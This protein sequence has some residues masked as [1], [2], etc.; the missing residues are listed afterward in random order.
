MALSLTL[1]LGFSVLGAATDPKAAILAA[2]RVQPKT[3][4]ALLADKVA[5]SKPKLLQVGF[6]ELYRDGHI[7]GS[8]YAGPASEKKG[9]KALEAAV[10]GLKRESPLVI[11][12]GCCPWEHCPNV[13]PAYQ[14]LKALGFKHVQVL[15]MDHGLDIDWT[16]Q[17]FPT[18]KPE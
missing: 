17:G 6:I 9:L 14:R 10:K 15:E 2:D 4:A 3:L 13:L 16:K 12:C 18:T 8:V 5:K 11:Y 1:L 7:P